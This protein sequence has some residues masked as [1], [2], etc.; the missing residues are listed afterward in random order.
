MAFKSPQESLSTRDVRRVK[1]NGGLGNGE[2]QQR[3]ISAAVTGKLNEGET[4]V[5]GR[6]YDAQEARGGKRTQEASRR[7]EA[8][9]ELMSDVGREV[10][11]DRINTAE[12]YCRMYE[13]GSIR[14]NRKNE[15]IYNA[16]APAISENAGEKE[17][18]VFGKSDKW[19]Q[20][21]E[22]IVVKKERVNARLTVTAQQ[23]APA[24]QAS[25]AQAAEQQ[26]PSC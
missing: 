9:L 15:E 2:K 11:Y 7:D 18:K 1:A 24:P 19:W 13:E 5:L 21:V 10:I 26:A 12:I 4:E 17:M 16:L 6:K 23:A 14:K 3:K 20:K 22:L 25:A 8:L